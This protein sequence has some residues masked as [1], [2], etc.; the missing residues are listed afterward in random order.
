VNGKT[1]TGQAAQDLAVAC[2]S[3]PADPYRH[4]QGYSTI[5]LV[6]PEANSIYNAL[7]VAIRRQSAR[8]QFNIAYTYSHSIDDSSDRYDGNFLDSYNM[9]LTR[10][11]S[12]FDQRH[13]LN[14]GYVLELP[15]FSSHRGFVGKTLGG[16]QLSGL[17]SFQTGTPFSVVANN[18]GDILVGPGVGNGS[19][20]NA[21][22]DLVGNPNASIPVKNSA[23]EVGSLL[24]N[25]SA[26][27]APRGLTFGDAGRNIL[28]NPSRL[29]FDMGLFKKF[30]I[31]EDMNFE[32]RAE[33]FNVFNHTQFESVYHTASCYG[34]ANNTTGD[35][36]CLDQTFLRPS[37]AHLPRILQLG[38]K[39]IF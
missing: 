16:W 39:F 8:S 24:Y 36:S 2:G 22:L 26:F 17:T 34:G 29:N 15:F 23:V 25:P 37:S 38:L 14:I 31:K 21:Y 30:Y 11:S 4:Y 12:N 32:F 13:I 18:G 20:T 27:A 5:T 28:R 7:Q 33:A 10:A 1:L 3:S 35:A 19:G 9:G 6:E